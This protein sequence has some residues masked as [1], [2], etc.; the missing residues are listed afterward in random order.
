MHTSFPNTHTKA[1]CALENGP[2]IPSAKY[3]IVTLWSKNEEKQMKI[4]T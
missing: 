4:S 1:L 2:G 3:K